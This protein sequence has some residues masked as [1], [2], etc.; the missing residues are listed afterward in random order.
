MEC[1]EYIVL[2][3]I[4]LY[5]PPVLNPMS[6]N[7]ARVLTSVLLSAMQVYLA[8][9]DMTEQEIHLRLFLRSSVVLL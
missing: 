4:V 3:C 8:A 2:Y 9:S 1:E 7:G 5:L 6:Y